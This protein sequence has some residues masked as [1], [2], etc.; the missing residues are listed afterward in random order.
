M[1]GSR[2]KSSESGR[3]WRGGVYALGDEP[4]DDVCAST[5]PEERL[6]ILAELTERA[7]SLTGKLFPEYGRQDI[8]ANVIRLS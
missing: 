7:W 5:T 4:P 2:M 3:V 1:T 8:P 6:A